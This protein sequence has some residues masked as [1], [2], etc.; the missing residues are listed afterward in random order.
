MKSKRQI[1]RLIKKEEI[2]MSE[3]FSIGHFG[4]AVSTTNASALQP[5]QNEMP[6]PSF[7]FNV[8]AHQNNEDNTSITSDRFLNNES[9]GEEMEIT[10]TPKSLKNKLSDWAIVYKP[11]RTSFRQLLIILKEEGLNVPISPDTIVKRVQNNSIKQFSNG[12][13]QHFDIESQILKYCS[14]MG[15][16]EVIHLDIN[17]DGLPLFDSSR[18]QLWPILARIVEYE[19]IFPIGIF[20]GKTK[21]K[22]LHEYLQAFVSNMTEILKNGILFENKRIEVRIRYIICDT[23]ARAY[24]CGIKGH[25]SKSGCTKCTQEAKKIDGVLTYSTKIEKRITDEDFENRRYP[26]HHQPEYL[27]QKTPLELLGVKMISQVPLDIMH[28]VDLGVTKKFLHRIYFKHAYFEISQENLD[29]ISKS[30]E[31]VKKGIPKEFVRNARPLEEIV[32][33]KATEYRQFLLYSGIVALKN[34]IP[35]NLFYQFLIL[36][37]AFRLLLCTKNFNDNAKLAQR[38]LN[39]FVNN[40]SIL[41]GENSV[42]FNIHSLLHATEVGN[43]V[44]NLSEISAYPFENHLQKIK[45]Y[46]KKPSTILQQINKYVKYENV[47]QETLSDGIK[48]E[49]GDIV[50]FT[51]K[52]CYFSSKCPDNYCYLTTGEIVEIVSFGKADDNSFVGK[53]LQHRQPYFTEPIDSSVLL[54]T[55]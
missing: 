7:T 28:L 2:R 3:Q 44:N 49:N 10:E 32:Y 19:K 45:K 8:N 36:H 14:V 25:T 35:D 15:Y 22:D 27:H 9:G 11:G 40:F 42:S 21:P 20:L 48:I 38:L 4:V 55:Y 50:S 24:I 52:G 13:Y 53:K 18:T 41:F 30:L 37:T 17:V 47:I 16:K 26:N 46:V 5:N 23:P 33:W 54:S 12:S 1:K 43:N 34:H 31:N 29:S 51:L 39:T 6:S